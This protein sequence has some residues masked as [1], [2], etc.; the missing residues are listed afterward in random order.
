ME[1]FINPIKL[2]WIGR[3]FE[4]RPLTDAERAELG[5]WIPTQEDVEWVDQNLIKRT[6]ENPPD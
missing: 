4:K 3:D 1:R 5:P 6:K 2:D